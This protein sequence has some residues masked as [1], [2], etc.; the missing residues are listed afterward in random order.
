MSCVVSGVILPNFAKTWL[1]HISSDLQ[2]TDML[3]FLVSKYVVQA[4]E[5]L[6]RIGEVLRY[7]RDS[8]KVDGTRM[9]D[10]VAQADALNNTDLIRDQPVGEG[11]NLQF[12]T[13]YWMAVIKLHHFLVIF[14]NLLDNKITQEGPVAGVITPVSELRAQ[15]VVSLRKLRQ[16]GAE[17]LHTARRLLHNTS[18]VPDIS[19]TLG[20][21]CH[22]PQYDFPICWADAHR[23]IPAISVVAAVPSMESEQRHEAGVILKTIGSRFRIGQALVGNHH[24]PS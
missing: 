24:I 8:V 15:R 17:I 20:R 1:E 21:V 2:S 12:Y 11:L 22:E 23:L 9:L 4:C 6:R 10:L 13:T 3:P 16:T 19:I 5:I 7:T 18:D 14:F